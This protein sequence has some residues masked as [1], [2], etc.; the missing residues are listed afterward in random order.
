MLSESDIVLQQWYMFGLGMCL[1]VTMVSVVSLILVAA[2]FRRS[3][4]RR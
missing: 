2:V 3:L 1:V 4:H